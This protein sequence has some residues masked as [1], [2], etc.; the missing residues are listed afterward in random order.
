[1]KAFLAS[2]MLIAASVTLSSAVGAAAAPDRPPGVSAT[3]WVPISAN[4]GLVLLPPQGSELPPYQRGPR[5]GPQLRINPGG[6][7]LLV[8]PPA[9]GYFVVRRGS[10]WVRLQVVSPG[11]VGW[12]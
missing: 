6:Q 4:F 5:S 1:M 12:A 9:Q 10:I 8:L 3:R 7:A 2:M 11:L